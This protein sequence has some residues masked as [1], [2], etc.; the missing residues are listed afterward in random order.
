[1]EAALQMLQ[2]AAA[3]VQGAPPNAPA[4]P[5]NP[6]GLVAALL[7]DLVAKPDDERRRT[8]RLTDPRRVCLFLSLSP[9]K[10]ICVNIHIYIFPMKL[11]LMN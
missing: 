7:R 8:I 9:D 4:A 2:A 1:M 11:L 10:Y 6:V 5:V 3:E